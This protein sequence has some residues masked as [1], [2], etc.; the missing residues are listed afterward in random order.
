MAV[1]E[2][3]IPFGK[4]A[5]RRLSVLPMRLP[6]KNWLYQVSHQRSTLGATICGSDLRSA[7]ITATQAVRNFDETGQ[8]LR[9]PPFSPLHGGTN[10]PRPGFR[11]WLSESYSDTKGV[12]ARLSVGHCNYKPI[13]RLIPV[14]FAIDAQHCYGGDRFDSL[15]HHRYVL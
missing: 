2:Q 8:T 12:I 1:S 15:I 6:T 11:A 13:W 7:V 3:Q 4:V 9:H 10:K 5:G 14:D